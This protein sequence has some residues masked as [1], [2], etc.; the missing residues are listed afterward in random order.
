MTFKHVIEY[1]DG[2]MPIHGRTDPLEKIDLLHQM[3]EDAGRDPASIELT[4][5][6]CPMSPEVVERYRAAGAQRIVFWLPATAE[7]EVL[8]A[9]EQGAAFIN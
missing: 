5:Y 6:G 7:S 8:E 3:A 1:C 9:V 4:I 2:W